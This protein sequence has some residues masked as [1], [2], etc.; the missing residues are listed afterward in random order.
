MAVRTLS[1]R[2]ASPG[3]ES[4]PLSLGRNSQLTGP[5]DDDLFA[6]R[7]VQKLPASLIS[8]ELSAHQQAPDEKV[9]NLLAKLISSE[10]SAHQ[11]AP[12]GV[13]GV[14]PWGSLSHVQRPA[15]C[16]PLRDGDSDPRRPCWTFFVALPSRF[17]ALLWIPYL[18]RT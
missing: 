17:P 13:I 18:W 14:V 10:L 9:Q 1:L 8:S 2:V 6:G 4:S 7:N 3:S 5:Q 11:M 12:S 16:T 15:R